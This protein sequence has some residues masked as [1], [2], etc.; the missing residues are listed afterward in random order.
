MLFM[1]R[2]VF[3]SFSLNIRKA[4]FKRLFE[5]TDHIAGLLNSKQNFQYNFKFL[6]FATTIN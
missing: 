3:W 4:D 1:L 5:A 2:I 6:A